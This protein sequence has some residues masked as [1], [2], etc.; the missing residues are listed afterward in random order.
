MM[1]VKNRGNFPDNVTRDSRSMGSLQSNLPSLEKDF[2]PRLQEGKRD[3][4]VTGQL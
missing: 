3:R 4:K 1:R 2:T